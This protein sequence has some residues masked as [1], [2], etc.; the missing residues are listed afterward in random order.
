MLATW[1]HKIGPAVRPDQNICQ[2]LQKSHRSAVTNTAIPQ[3]RR[4]HIDRAYRANGERA[5]HRAPLSRQR[6]SSLRYSARYGRSSPP[7]D[8]VE[9]EPD[10]GCGSRAWKVCADT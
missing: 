8:G 1:K 2:A 6:E 4:L 9:C 3:L 5:K 10:C 7:P